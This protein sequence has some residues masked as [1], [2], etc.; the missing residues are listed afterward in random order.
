MSASIGTRTAAVVEDCEFM[1]DAG[2]TLTGAARRLGYRDRSVL[3]RV[4]ARAGRADLVA[5]LKAP[6]T[7]QLIAEQRQSRWAVAR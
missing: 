1:A 4:L 3:D 7:E 6:E 2:E 5:R